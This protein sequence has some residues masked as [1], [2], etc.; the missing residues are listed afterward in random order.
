LLD[1][2]D[3]PDEPAPDHRRLIAGVAHAFLDGALRAWGPLLED[4]VARL[5][6]AGL[7]VVQ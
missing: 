7:R 3:R 6:R 2:L 5:S 4:L 1:F